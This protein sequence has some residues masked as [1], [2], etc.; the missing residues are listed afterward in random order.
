MPENL[1][2]ISA[3]KKPDTSGEDF[4]RFRRLMVIGGYEHGFGTLPI[5]SVSQ[6]EIITPPDY[7][8]SSQGT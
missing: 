6:K 7:E 1:E 8:N 3:D 4:K 2:R 5:Q